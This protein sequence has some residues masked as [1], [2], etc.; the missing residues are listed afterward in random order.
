VVDGG[1]FAADGAGW[2]LL[3]FDGAELHGLGVERQQAVGAQPNSVRR[4]RSSTR[5]SG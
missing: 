1:V 4:C 3:D 2:S 5:Q